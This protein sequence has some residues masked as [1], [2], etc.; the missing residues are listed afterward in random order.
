MQNRSLE[1]QKRHRERLRRIRNQRC[2][3]VTTLVAI[4]SLFVTVMIFG[5]QRYWSVKP[6]LLTVAHFEGHLE[7]EMTKFEALEERLDRLEHDIRWLWQH[8]NRSPY[9]PE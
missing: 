9:S 4:T 5:L 8:Q 3:P 7:A 6:A 1:A 2:V